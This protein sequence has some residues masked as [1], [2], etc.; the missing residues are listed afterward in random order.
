MRWRLGQE[1]LLE[2]EETLVSYLTSCLPWEQ[3]RSLSQGLALDRDLYSAL[4]PRL[5]WHPENYSW[6]D[7]W[8]GP[9]CQAKTG[10]PERA[11][12]MV[13]SDRTG[14]CQVP[15]GEAGHAGF[16]ALRLKLVT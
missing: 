9:S 12:P 6:L 14:M 1:L 11:R 2:Y 3:L 10:E 13:R 7:L 8:M 5:T 15:T 4:K 16:R